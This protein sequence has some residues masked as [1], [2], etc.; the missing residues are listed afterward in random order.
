MA[1]VSCS[2]LD[3]YGGT[4]KLLDSLWSCPRGDPDPPESLEEVSKES[5]WLRPC[6][7]G[8]SA[9]TAKRPKVR[10]E[11]A[12][13]I[14]GP[15]R[16]APKTNQLPGA[17]PCFRLFPP[18]RNRVGT[19]ERLFWNS[20]PRGTNQFFTILKRV[21]A[22]NDCFDTCARRQGHRVG[23]GG[24]SPRTETRTRVHNV[25][26]MFPRSEDRTE[27]YVRMFPQNE[28]PER[29]HIRQNRPFTK[30]P[31]C[32]SLGTFLS[33]RDFFQVALNG[34]FE[35][36]GF[37][38]WAMVRTLSKD[39]GTLERTTWG[40]TNEWA[41]LHYVTGVYTFKLRWGMLTITP[42]PETATWC[43]LGPFAG[44]WGGFVQTSSGSGRE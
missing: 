13:G 41:V 12:Q 21:W 18:V 33:F 9:K 1:P 3:F 15:P 40:H 35:G 5:P 6:W 11:S 44:F 28:N 23:F 26:R 10:K 17:K 4:S 34:V 16:W 31:F 30:P 25:I 7:P 37:A 20:R 27:G 24:C 14:F 42:P 36:G 19:V 2:P 32:N 38:V 8:T 39:S 43:C 29:G 22:I